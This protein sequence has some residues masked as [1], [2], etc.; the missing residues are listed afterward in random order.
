MMDFMLQ[1][2]L[3]KKDIVKE[4]KYDYMFS[5]ENVNQ[6]VLEGIAFRDAYKNIGLEI[7]NNEFKPNHVINHS[8]EGSI[9]NLCNELIE[10]SFYE[11]K[12]KFN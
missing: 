12:D 8:H 9:G 3:I 2:I 6:Q 10:K 4:T 7:E 5:V 1:H 11:L